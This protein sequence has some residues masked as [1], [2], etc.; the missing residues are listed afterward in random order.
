VVEEVTMVVVVVVELIRPE[1]DRQ[2]EAVLD[3]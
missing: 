2:R 3:M 1:V